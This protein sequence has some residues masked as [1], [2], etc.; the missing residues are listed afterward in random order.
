MNGLLFDEFPGGIILTLGAEATLVTLAALI[1]AAAIRNPARRHAV[2]FAAMICLLVSPL[3]V[4][5]A[6]LSGLKID[7][8][9][10]P[11]TL[12]SQSQDQVKQR[13]VSDEL[14]LPKLRAKTDVIAGLPDRNS[15][16]ANPRPAAD[17]VKL[18]HS[19]FSKWRPDSFLLAAWSLGILVGLLGIARASWAMSRLLRTIQPLEGGRYTDVLEQAARR[20][21]LSRYPPIGITA[22]ISVP[23]VAGGFWQPWVLFPP[24]CLEQL[25]S[26]QLLQVLVHEGAHVVR[27][28]LWSVLLQR[29]SAALFWWHP[30]VHLV[31]RELSRC[32][33][34]ICDNYVLR[35]V[36]P[37]VYGSTL[38]H[39]AQLT[40]PQT[41]SAAVLGMFGGRWRLEHRVAGLLAPRRSTATRV[42]T[43]GLTSVLCGFATLSM[44]AAATRVV[45]DGPEPATHTQAVKAVDA[46][47]EQAPVQQQRLQNTFGI[48]RIHPSQLDS[49]LWRE[50][51]QRLDSSAVKFRSVDIDENG[52][53]RLNLSTTPTTDLSH[54]QGMPLDSLDLSETAVRDLSPL[55]GM[56]LR[57]LNIMGTQ[58]TDLSP[59]Q[60]MKLRQLQMSSLPVRDLAPL[61]EAELKQLVI[62][63]VPVSDLTPLSRMPLEYLDLRR[64]NVTDLSP[65]ATTPLK[66]LQ[67]EDS[68]LRDLTPL[69]KLPVELLW[70]SWF[71]GMDLSQLQGLAVK[72]LVL[73]GPQIANV[74]PVRGLKLESITLE[75]TSVHDLAPLSDMPLHD[76][77]FPRSPV[78]DLSPLKGLKLTS[79]TVTQAG[80]DLAP[81]SGMP[82]EM[83]ALPDPATVRNLDVLRNLA[84][85]KWIRPPE[86]KPLPTAEFWQRF[87]AKE[88]DAK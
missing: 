75:N 86:C 27:R 73:T 26:A 65:L 71:D 68:P 64:T 20:L 76:A 56:P 39:L 47:V 25:S 30:L 35:G 19:A 66:S 1:V 28:D 67:I 9:L 79:L 23:S 40:M 16:V 57:T 82:L 32:R 52:L 33:E 69:Q 74:E 36:E 3:F 50:L 53:C 63:G 51:K 58:V 78:T 5:T 17:P 55:R 60:G 77:H 84:T 70:L 38:L 43:L 62:I 31:H 59:L 88:A 15:E 2:L 29:I 18:S 80:A 49:Q 48:E 83:I 87:A 45:A 11:N 12:V 7:V 72:R 85:L 8:P 44:I 61:A 21:G 37:E 42:H 41:R 46:Q 22:Q 24:A 81:L 54:L 4:A 34:E 14:T 6:S 13:D 10:L